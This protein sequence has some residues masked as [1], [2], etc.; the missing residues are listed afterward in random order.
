MIEAITTSEQE[1]QDAE[2]LSIAARHW[3]Q[4]DVTRWHANTDDRLRMSWDTI[5]N[6]QA[7]CLQ[8]LDKL[9]PTAPERLR[10]IVRHH[11]EAERIVGDMPYPAK[12]AFPALAAAYQAAEAQIMAQMGHP[13]P[14]T[15]EERMWLKLVDRLDAQVWMLRH[16]PDLAASD[17]WRE[18]AE[19]ITTAA[20]TLGVLAPVQAI[21]EDAR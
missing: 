14:E 13:V 19:L 15:H 10:Q 18:S 1:W 17:V 11:D 20:H 3:P 5:G 2:T 9:H 8:Y 16:A 4:G 7:R 12:Q 6:H 21:M